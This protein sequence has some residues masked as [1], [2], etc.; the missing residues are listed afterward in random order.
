MQTW[1]SY[2]RAPCR[3]S[4][5]IVGFWFCFSGFFVCV[6]L[7]NLSKIK[8]IFASLPARHTDRETNHLPAFSFTLIHL[9]CFSCYLIF[10]FCLLKLSFLSGSEI[11]VA[12]A[13]FLHLFLLPFSPAFLKI[14]LLLFCRTFSLLRVSFKNN[15]WLFITLV[16]AFK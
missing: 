14:L 12:N 2:W 9:S 7:E 6:F 11:L 5:W 1:F 3:L 15:C 13:D 10:L 16:E 8:T 4:M